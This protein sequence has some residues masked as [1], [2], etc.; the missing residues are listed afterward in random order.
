MAVVKGSIEPKAEGESMSNEDL[1]ALINKQKKELEELKKKKEV[2]VSSQSE[3]TTAQIVEAV[4]KSMSAVNK[5][6]ADG[7]LTV[8]QLDP[9]D[10]M[11]NG[12]IFFSYG[13]GFYLNGDIRFGREVKSPYGNPILFKY[14]HSKKSQ[15]GK[16]EVIQKWCAYDCKSKKELAWLRGHSKYKGEFWEDSSEAN[17]SM[18]HRAKL[19]AA[20]LGALNSLGDQQIMT[21]L[22]ERGVEITTRDTQL[23]RTSLANLMTKEQMESEKKSAMDKAKGSRLEDLLKLKEKGVEVTELGGLS[24]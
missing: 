9:D 23:W 19:M 13:S 3:L 11:E 10:F 5:A 20:N 17:S 22:I 16:Y 14:S 7:V 12:V 4:V 18:P 24:L 2:V 1:L 8:E 6:N 15:E 21:R